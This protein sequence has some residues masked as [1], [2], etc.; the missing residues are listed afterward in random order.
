M[1]G[2]KYRRQ[3][4]ASLSF[5]DLLGLEVKRRFQPMPAVGLP[6]MGKVM[7]LAIP[8]FS[9]QRPAAAWANALAGQPAFLH[10][11]NVD[12]SPVAQT[13]GQFYSH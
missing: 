5:K 8:L 13:E 11:A 10:L 1:I 3:Y 6:V 2:Q 9:Q 4:Q 7:R 12:H